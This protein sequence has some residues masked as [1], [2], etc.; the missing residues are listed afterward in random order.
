[1]KESKLRIFLIPLAAALT[2]YFVGFFGVEYMRHRKGPWEVTFSS[3]DGFAA[4]VVNQAKL[5]IADV[6]IVLSND[7]VAAGFAESVETYSEPREVPFDVPHGRVVYVDMTF[8]PGTVT[9][10][11]Q[12]H[13]IELLPRAL[14][15]NGR[16]YPW[17]NGQH[18]VLEPD[19]KKHPV[20]PKEFIQRV[21]DAKEKAEA[22]N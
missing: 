19:D 1:M 10:D 8:L 5:G 3:S 22:E 4:I 20:T 6:T 2:I 13:A 21:K 7:M 11:L 14:L 12:G 9:Y 18:I 17:E 16:E 15:I